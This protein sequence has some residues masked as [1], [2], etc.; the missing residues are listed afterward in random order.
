MG[1]PITTEQLERVRSQGREALCEFFL[2]CEL[3]EQSGYKLL[4]GFFPMS[5]REFRA[6]EGRVAKSVG[7]SC[8]VYVP[9]IGEGTEVWRQV[10]AVRVRPGTFRLGGPVPEGE[11]WAFTPGELVRCAVRVFSD[12]EQRLAAFERAEDEQAPTSDCPR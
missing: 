7:Q 3:N 5:F 6:L 10:P 8:T 9:L 4:K 12:A 1:R 2:A 11:S